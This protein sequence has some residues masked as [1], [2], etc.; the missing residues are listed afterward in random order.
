MADD[1]N[2]LSLKI[3][4]NICINKENYLKNYQKLEKSDRILRF[5]QVFRCFIVYLIFFHLHTSP[6]CTRFLTDFE[7]F[8]SNQVT[9]RS[10]SSD[11]S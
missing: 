9:Y 4:L 5:T 3:M 8:S 7:P 2:K 6:L 1:V 10:L 11:H